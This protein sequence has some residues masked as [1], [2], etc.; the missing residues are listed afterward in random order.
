M[1][2]FASTVLFYSLQILY[3]STMGA[4][5]WKFMGRTKKINMNM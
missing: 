5:V 4:D 1:Q 2:Q 3:I